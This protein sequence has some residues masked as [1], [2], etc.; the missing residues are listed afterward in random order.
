MGFILVCFLNLP[1]LAVGLVGL[2]TAIVYV[3]LYHKNEGA[4]TNND[5][6][7]EQIGGEF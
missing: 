7:F 6:D 5:A 4:S 1:M 2:I 3:E